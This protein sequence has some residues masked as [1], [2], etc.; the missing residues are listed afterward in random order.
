MVFRATAEVAAARR[1]EEALAPGPAQF[2]GF[3]ADKVP[4]DVQQCYYCVTS[5]VVS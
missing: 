2:R 4:P 3:H 1:P 5:Y